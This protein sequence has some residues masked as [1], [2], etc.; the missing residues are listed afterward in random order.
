MRRVHRDGVN[1]VS[2]T[3]DSVPENE[4]LRILE[5]V[6][7]G[8]ITADEG[9]LLLQ[10]LAEGGHEYGA[11]E[12][13]GQE[14]EIASPGK[15]GRGRNDML[16]DV[17]T[18]TPAPGLRSAAMPADETPAEPAHEYAAHEYGA[19]EDGASEAVEHESPAAKRWRSWWWIPMWVG[20]GITVLGGLFMYLAWNSGGFGF[21][22][23]CAWFPFLFGVLIMALA[24]ASRTARWL[25]LRVYQKPGEHPQKIAI[26]LPLPLGLASWGA[27]TFGRRI[28]NMENMNLDEMVMALKHATPESPFFVE[29]QEDDG[30]RVEIYIG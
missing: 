21:W 27:R 17:P 3:N 10:A 12:Y 26:S 25:H 28:P 30:E 6:D 19:H 29:V 24:W 8:I 11:H 22:F 5:M 23:A 9:V 13:D 7:Q 2:N 14:R 1:R 20:I 18:N 16:G 4:Q 15:E